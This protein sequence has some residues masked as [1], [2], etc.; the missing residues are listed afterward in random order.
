MFTLVFRSNFTRRKGQ[1]ILFHMRIPH[2]QSACGKNLEI[3]SSNSNFLNV[4]TV[5]QHR[6]HAEKKIEKISTLI[7]VR[8]RWKFSKY[9][10]LRTDCPHADKMNTFFVRRAVRRKS[11]NWALEFRYLEH[12]LIVSFYVFDFYLL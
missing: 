4:S 5:F 9:F 1:F 2:P 10:P 11:M 8:N 12:V 3:F 7:F 6:P